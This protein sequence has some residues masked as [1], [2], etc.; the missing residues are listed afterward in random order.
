MD[1]NVENLEGKRNDSIIA[2]QGAAVSPAMV[3]L[4]NQTALSVC[5]YINVIA[6]TTVVALHNNGVKRMLME[7]LLDHDN[8]T[9][10]ER[11]TSES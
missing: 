2:A 4:V 9:T 7:M 1:N 8:K 10:K 6:G 5:K 3:D 11:K